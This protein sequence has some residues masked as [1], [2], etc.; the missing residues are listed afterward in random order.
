MRRIGKYRVVRRL[1]EGAYGEVYAAVLEGPMGFQKRVAIKLIRQENG[2]N[3]G[4]FLKTLASEARIGGL[5]RHPNVG[6]VLEFGEARGRYYLAMEYVDGVTLSELAQVARN[7][8]RSLPVEAV[9]GLGA[10]ICGGLAYVH[11][12]ADLEGSPL[13][14]VHR[15]IK[16]SNLMV[17]RTGLVKILDFGIARA[18]AD[19]GL[20]RGT[21]TATGVFRGTLHYL[22]PEQVGSGDEV[23]PPTDLFALGAVLFELT[24]GKRLFDG[25][26]VPEVLGQILTAPLDERGLLVQQRSPGLSSVLAR[27]LARDPQERYGDAVDAGRDLRALAGDVDLAE[28]LAPFMMAYDNTIRPEAREQRAGAWWETLPWRWGA[29]A[30]VLAG[31][32][33]GAWQFAARPPAVAPVTAGLDAVQRPVPSSTPATT[34]LDRADDESAVDEAPASSP[35][36]VEAMASTPPTQ[37]H[38][39]PPA[40]AGPTRAASASSQVVGTA[41]S[42][43][44]PFQPWAEVFVDGVRVGSFD[45]LSEHPLEAGEHE[46]RLRCTALDQPREVVRRLEIDGQD[47]RLECWD[48]RREG[49]CELRGIDAP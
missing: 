23:G 15:D 30:L 6:E 13:G 17:D 29:A 18:D 4:A 46:I 8:G 35:G 26:T 9:A 5:L 31:I 49:P 19:C 33:L 36:V 28:A 14:L 3:G 20:A 11:A 34:A 38:A 22:A 27:L 2:A 47:A 25:S 41:G 16:P 7:F 45:G 1:G 43:T 42:V 39:A 12:A 32:G 24:T 48:F 40:P 21:A 44:W 10:Q 37:G